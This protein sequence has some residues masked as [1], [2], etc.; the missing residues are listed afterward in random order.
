MIDG[1][2]WII[3]HYTNYFMS[4]V[5]Q[6]LCL[7]GHSRLDILKVCTVEEDIMQ[8][9]AWKRLVSKPKTRWNEAVEEISRKKKLNVR[10]WKREAMDVQCG[11]AICRRP[12]FDMGPLRHKEEEEYFSRWGMSGANMA[13]VAQQSISLGM[14]IRR[15]EKG[16][17]WCLE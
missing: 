8:G 13:V 12:K 7:N 5:Y 16:A 3:M 1:V 17:K 14:G 10:N 4:P 11:K 15:I 6:L 2:Q 9:S